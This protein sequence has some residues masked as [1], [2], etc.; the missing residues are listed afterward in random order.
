MRE[1]KREQRDKVFVGYERIVEYVSRTG[2]NDKAGAM[3]E[4]CAAFLRRL[5]LFRAH[6]GVISCLAGRITQT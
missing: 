1:N 3:R 5:F 6:V 2:I 4:I